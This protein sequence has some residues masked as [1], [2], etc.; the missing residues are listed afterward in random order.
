MAPPQ[1]DAQYRGTCHLVVNRPKLR[2]LG[3]P[4]DQN[5][6][7]EFLAEEL[8]VEDSANAED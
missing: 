8:L 5:Y 4:E 3:S 7:R 2:A 6:D 1:L